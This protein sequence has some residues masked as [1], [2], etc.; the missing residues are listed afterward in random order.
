MW[1]IAL[2]SNIKYTICPCNAKQCKGYDE[3]LESNCKY[4][5]LGFLE[6]K[7][8]TWDSCHSALKEIAADAEGGKNEADTMRDMRN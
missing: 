7:E 3:R 4:F 1:Q 5:V 2:N 6:E 8:V